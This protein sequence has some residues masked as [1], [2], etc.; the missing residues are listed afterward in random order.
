[1][2]ALSLAF[3]SLRNRLLTSTLTVCSIALSVMLLL[4]VEGVRRGVRESFTNT[5]SQTDLIVGARGGTI[6]L[7]LY[8]VFGLGSPTA[9]VS[10][11]TF[12]HF[13]EHPAVAWTVPYSLGDSHRGFRVIG[14]TADFFE[15]YRYRRDRAVEFAAG[16]PP[17]DVFETAIGSHVAA[18]L[19]YHLGD[20][21]TLT[22]GISGGPGI[23]DHRDKPVRV[24]GIIEG[25]STPIDRAVYVTL[26][27]ITAIHVDW[28]EGAPP[29]PGQARS[30]ADVRRSELEVEQITAFFL[31]TRSRIDSLRLQREINTYSGEALMAIIPGVALAEMWRG[32]GYAE[33][34]LQVI[35]ACVI[36]V[37]LL[38]MLVSIYTSLDER[39]REMA[40]LRALGARPA[41]ICALLLLESGLLSIA[42]CLVGVAALYVALIAGQPVVEGR[43]G[44]YVPVQAL[45]RTEYAFLAAVLACGFLIGVVPAIKAYRN[46]VGDGLTVRL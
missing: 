14:T 5:I 32:I 2:I 11:E 42:G 41:K 44:L 31:G 15:R 21:I 45:A 12:E 9:N 23:M 18:E 4:G 28:Q 19:G 43:F 29:L 27:S 16:G 40:I 37:G 8:T 7:L 17:E 25:T 34:A 39:R 46:S 26:E 6:Q 3:Q 35:S 1:M 10:Y 33:S 36:A 20:E 38:G 22:H 30:A 24:V 13:T